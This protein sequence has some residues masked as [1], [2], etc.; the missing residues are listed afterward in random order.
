M[1]TTV[2]RDAL[3]GWGGV[4]LGGGLDVKLLWHDTT[5]STA[6]TVTHTAGVW[7][8]RLVCILVSSVMRG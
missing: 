8:K 4:G 1:M 6:H 5:H 3:E 7:T 2:E